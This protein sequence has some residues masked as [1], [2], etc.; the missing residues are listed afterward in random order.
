MA[1]SSSARM[2]AAYTQASSELAIFN[3]GMKFKSKSSL[4]RHERLHKNGKMQQFNEFQESANMPV[5]PSKRYKCSECELTFQGTSTLY[6]HKQR[7]HEGKTFG[8]GVCGK[9]YAYMH[10]MKTHCI[11]QGHDE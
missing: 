4:L 9:V 1:T 5:K 2:R 6:R 8:C 7:F 11:S 10:N 3:C